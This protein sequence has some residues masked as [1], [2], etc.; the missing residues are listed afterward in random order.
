MISRQDRRRAH[1]AGF[2]LIE[3]LVSLVILVELIVGVL[4]LFDFN[5]KLARVQTNVADMQQSLRVAQYEV[6]R[7][8]RM[9]GRGGFTGGG[10][11]AGGPPESFR[12]MAVGVLNNTAADVGILGGAS[13]ATNPKVLPGTDVLTVRGVISGSIYQLNHTDIASYTLVDANGDDV[14]ESG[15]VVVED[16]TP[17]GIPQQLEPWNEA[18]VAARPEG[19]VIMSPVS[20]DHYAVVEFDP[21]GTTWPPADSNANGWPDITV[22]F[23]VADA[24]YFT[25]YFAINGG[26]WP[27]A[28][29]NTTRKG[30]VA[31]LGL[32]EEI[33]YYVREEHV[34]P[35]DTTSELSP[36]LARARV[37]PN[38]SVAAGGDVQNLT[39]DLADNIWDFQVALGFDDD[40]VVGAAGYGTVDEDLTTIANDEW[41][42]NQA[43]D[44]PAD[45]GKW[46]ATLKLSYV[47]V[48]TLALTDRRDFKYRAPALTA[49][50]DHSFSG[51]QLNASD[52]N[53]MFRHRVQQTVVDLRNF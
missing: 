51:H 28:L 50:E 36:R 34:D 38:T 49:V 14:P 9:A 23:N 21:A 13:S 29:G 33:R 11:F 19:M 17:G 43:A 3:L 45:A 18:K 47:R 39:A 35:A 22:A 53:R 6:Q 26:T 1:A 20:D 48:S 41:L 15:S 16:H 42:F 31:Y 46:P 2:T 5:N 44:D 52:A 24:T 7:T 12:N 8:T 10:T 30:S 37:Y 27:V 40:A 32:L 4:M 25:E